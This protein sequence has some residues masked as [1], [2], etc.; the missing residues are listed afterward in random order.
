[1]IETKLFEIRDHGTF[2][3]AVGIACECS[4]IQDEREQWLM[5]RAGYGERWI[6]LTRL[7]GGGRAEYDPHSW[8]NRTW[9]GAHLLIQRDWDSLE[10]GDV[11]DARV[12]LGETEQPVPSERIES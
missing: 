10:S 12:G 9:V 6:L 8:T 3:P 11:I 7:D 5:R 2:I 1:M 4:T